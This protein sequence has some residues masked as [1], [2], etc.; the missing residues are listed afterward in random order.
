MENPVILRD[1]SWLSFNHRVL[2]EA[3]DESLPLFERLKFL[4]IYSSNLDEF[5]RVR[6]ANHRNLL[7]V[8]K[9]TKK[10]LDITPKQ[11]VRTIQR[12]VN[13]QQE[14]FSRIFEKKI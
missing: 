3:K 14:E 12:I 11:T 10:E 9:K 5:F 2:Q 8:G 13:R 6:M 1:I 7:R 4:A